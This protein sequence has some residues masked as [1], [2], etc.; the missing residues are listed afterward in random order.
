MASELLGPQ[1]L[2]SRS[3]LELKAKVEIDALDFDALDHA[4]DSICT[5]LSAA[6][7]IVKLPNMEEMANKGHDGGYGSDEGKGDRDESVVVREDSGLRNSRDDNPLNDDEYG[8][9]LVDF[10]MA[11]TARVQKIVDDGIIGR[12]LITAVLK[13][14]N[15]CVA[16]MQ[17]R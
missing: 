1:N 17:G 14:E 13:T 15:M 11:S 6:N 9:Q 4:V 5:L 12:I 2:P 16:C 3:H 10:V 7:L 8:K